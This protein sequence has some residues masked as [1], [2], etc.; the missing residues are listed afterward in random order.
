[1]NNLSPEAQRVR[2]SL[3]GEPLSAPAV[4]LGGL[5]DLDTSKGFLTTTLQP[6][7][8]LWLRFSQ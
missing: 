1:L 4:L 3:T 5:V 2:L 7:Q 8:C 6:Y